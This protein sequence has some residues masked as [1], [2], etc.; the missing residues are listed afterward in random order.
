MEAL[1]QITQSQVSDQTTF[2]TA[3]QGDVNHHMDRLN[4]QQALQQRKQREQ[5][6]QQQQMRQEQTSSP[7]M[8]RAGF[9]NLKTI[10]EAEQQNDMALVAMDQSN[11]QQTGNTFGTNQ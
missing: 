7:E 1:K 9:D 8:D 6:Q 10:L 2:L 11:M 5:Q 3:V 4:Q